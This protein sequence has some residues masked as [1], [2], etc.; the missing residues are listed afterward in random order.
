MKRTVPSFFGII[1]VGAAHSDWFIFLSTPI[2]TSLSPSILR[3]FSCILGNGNGLAW[4]GCAPALRS[5]SY[6]L[7]FHLP[8]VP[9]NNILYFS[10]SL[11]SCY[12]YFKSRCVHPFVTSFKFAGS[13]LASR[14]CLIL[15]IDSSPALESSTK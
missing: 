9:S 12:R 15:S 11:Y 5:I 13:Y 4:Y 2:W 3:V 14:I 8:I 10:S 1:H 7:F 6:S